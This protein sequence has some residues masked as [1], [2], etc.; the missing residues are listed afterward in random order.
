[1]PGFYRKKPGVIEAEQ[2]DGT[3]RSAN[4]IALLLDHSR[5]TDKAR[6]QITAQPDG[7]AALMLRSDHGWVSCGARD[8][9]IKG[10]SGE[11]YP[12]S[13][14]KFADIYEPLPK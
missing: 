13:P 6:T 9:V 3:L 5:K 7:S 1:M 4:E 2:F 12:C 10:A 11:L 14:D 8:W